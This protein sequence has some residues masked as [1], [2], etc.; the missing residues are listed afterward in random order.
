MTTSTPRIHFLAELPKP[1]VDRPRVGCPY[2]KLGQLRCSDTSNKAL[3]R[4]PKFDFPPTLPEICDDGSLEEAITDA[5]AAASPG[6]YTP[7]YM[8]RL[9]SESS[10]ESEASERSRGDD[11]TPKSLD[12]AEV[13][14]PVQRQVSLGHA[15]RFR[16]LL[17]I[18]STSV[19]PDE[20]GPLPVEIE[21][22]LP[23]LPPLPPLPHKMAAQ[24]SS[25]STTSG[26][27]TSSSDGSSPASSRPP[28][29]FA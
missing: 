4:S 27:D 29:V 10:Q 28:S 16:K 1:P 15:Y 18:T 14:R 3:A 24:V 5:L 12:V 23:P 8:L 6:E 13:A 9:A 20:R 22:S 2:P 19:A 11:P 25:G 21:K 17:G 26:T 7:A